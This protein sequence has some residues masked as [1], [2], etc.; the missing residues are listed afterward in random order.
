[1]DRA[2]GTARRLVYGRLDA[3]VALTDECSRWI[4][5]HTSARSVPVIPNAVTFPLPCGAPWIVP[6]RVIAPWRRVLLAVGRLDPV[7]NLEGLLAVFAR[8]ANRHPG[9]D[10]VILGEGPERSALQVASVALGL[11]GR[12]LMPGI[13]GNIAHWHA[14][15]DLYVLSSHSEGFP[16]ALAEALCHGMPVVSVDCDTGPRD[17]IRHGIDGLLVAPGDPAALERA[18]DSL[19]GNS[20][21]RQQFAAQAAD[22]RQRFSIERIAGMWETLFSQLRGAEGTSR[23]PANMS[24]SQEFLS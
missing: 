5:T 19:M 10:L 20:A 13:A 12:V 15:C 24:D 6:N 8:L 17:I 1:M 14:R 22:A 7:K 3:V 4:A 11:E 9:W 18:L 21:F 16:N 2:W 23:R